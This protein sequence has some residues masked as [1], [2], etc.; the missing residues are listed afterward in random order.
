MT[1]VTMWLTCARVIAKLPL[2]S[3]VTVSIQC[4]LVNLAALTIEL[5]LT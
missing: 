4:A 5:G 1:G 2:G 3:A